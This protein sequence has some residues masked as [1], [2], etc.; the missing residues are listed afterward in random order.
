[1]RVLRPIFAALSAAI[2]RTAVARVLRPFGV[3]SAATARLSGVCWL[4]APGL[5]AVVCS[6]F[7]GDFR[8]RFAS[9]R[10]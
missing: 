2:A 8:A 5:L 3:V 9:W 4:A 7:G 10:R 1:V 6:A